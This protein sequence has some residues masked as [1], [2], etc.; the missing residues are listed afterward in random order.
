MNEPSRTA[1]T[2]EEQKEFFQNIDKG[3]PRNS[4]KLRL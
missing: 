4:R 2:K 1:D 3:S